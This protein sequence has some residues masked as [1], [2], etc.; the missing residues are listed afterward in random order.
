MLKT[1]LLDFDGVILESVNIKTNAF[2]ELFSE[3]VLEVDDIVQYHLKNNGMYRFKKFEYI[4]KHI[5]KKK[6]DETTGSKIGKKFSEMVF[7]RVVGCPFVAGAEEFLNFFSKRVPLYLISTT[8]QEELE[9]IVAKRNL[10]RYFEEIWGVPNKIEYIK[11]ALKKETSK[12]QEAIF[13]GDMV[14]DYL[15][16]KMAGVQFIGRRSVQ[17]FEEFKIPIFSNLIE[18]KKYILSKGITN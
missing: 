14:D 16:A 7:D 15:A 17:S 10:G 6:Y 3:Y 4:Y 18:I 11:R 1:I 13:I 5:L 8:P 9:G 2:R 12:P